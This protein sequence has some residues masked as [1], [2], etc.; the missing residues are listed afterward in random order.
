[1]GKKTVAR[2]Q[3]ST[4]FQIQSTDEQPKLNCTEW[5]LL[6]KNFDKLNVRTSH[7]TPIACGCSPLM[8]PIDEYIRS[9]IQLPYEYNLRATQFFELQHI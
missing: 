8:R 7:Y 4:Q 3:Q 9:V 1:M 6:L 2:L 5:P